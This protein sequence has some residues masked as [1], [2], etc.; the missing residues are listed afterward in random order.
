M[1]KHICGFLQN[2]STYPTQSSWL[3]H[4]QPPNPVPT[5]IVF[6]SL[7]YFLMGKGQN[8]NPEQNRQTIG[9]ILLCAAIQQY[10][11][12]HCQNCYKPSTPLQT[13]AYKLH[14]LLSSLILTNVLAAR[15][16]CLKVKS[17]ENMM[18]TC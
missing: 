3:H 13:K 17:S 5:D 14:Y 18:R 7:V 10:L 6:R 16:T 8:T 11:Y 9:K 12:S 2:I 15:C 1:V 4:L